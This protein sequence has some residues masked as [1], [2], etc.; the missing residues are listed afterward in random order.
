MPGPGGKGVMHAEI[1][2]GNAVIMLNDEFPGAPGAPKAPTTLKGTSAVI[3]LY[4]PDCDAV[5]KRAVDAGATATMPLMDA[6]WGD[7][8]GQLTDPFGHQW[9]IATHKQ[10]LTPEEIQK[11]AEA[12][13]KNMPGCQ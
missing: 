12:W 2:I 13:F 10:D 1:Q 5:Y 6:F 9:G 11:A 8:Y 4:V 3:H 7:R